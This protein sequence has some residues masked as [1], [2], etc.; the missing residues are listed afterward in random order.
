MPPA[1]QRSKHQALPFATAMGRASACVRVHAMLPVFLGNRNECIPAV[2]KS[3]VFRGQ[4][5]AEP[6]FP[7]NHRATRS[8]RGKPTPAAVQQPYTI[9]SS[10]GTNSTRASR[11]G[12]CDSH[13]DLS[14]RV[15]CR[16]HDQIRRKKRVTTAAA[17][18]RF[19]VQVFN[20]SCKHTSSNLYMLLAHGNA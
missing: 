14:V 5:V 19:L 9:S 4:D 15:C 12:L 1:P 16:V 20:S 11:S 7:R 13:G 8:H 6:R 17:A 18:V 2:S 10:S 3:G